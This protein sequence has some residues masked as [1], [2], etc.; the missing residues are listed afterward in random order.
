MKAAALEIGDLR[1]GMSKAGHDVLD[2]V[3]EWQAT[4]MRQGD[5]VIGLLEQARRDLGISFEAALHS[6]GAR[7][8]RA[9]AASA[10]AALI[11]AI[12]L[13]DEGATCGR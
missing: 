13:M 9:C 4:P 11:R 8:R 10:A 12:E 6:D 1:Q 5:P 7:C 3:D 2:L